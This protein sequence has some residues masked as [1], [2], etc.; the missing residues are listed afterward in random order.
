MSITH[1]H[2]VQ[3]AVLPRAA[4]AFFIPAPGRGAQMAEPEVAVLDVVQ[5]IPAEWQLP[6]VDPKKTPLLVLRGP[7]RALHSEVYHKSE[8][9]LNC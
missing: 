4:Q 6:Q 5:Q 8:E 7:T 1:V 3:E 2:F 9:H